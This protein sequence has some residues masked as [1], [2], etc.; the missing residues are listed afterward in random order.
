MDKRKFLSKTGRRYTTLRL[1]D[2]DDVTIR[3]L[4]GG[5][6]RLFRESL[7]DKKG[8]L[9]KRRGDMLNE[10]LL[11]RCL[12]G[13]DRQPILTDA[14]AMSGALDEMDGAVILTIAEACKKWTGFKT[15]GDFS[16]IEDA[17]K[18]SDDDRESSGC[19]V[20]PPISV[21]TT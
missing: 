1:P 20:S 7:V 13:D 14:E 3:S 11:V 4:T 16:A 10:L 12:V 6:M 9:I 5:E 15:D 18:N 8:E 17:I 21:V 2:G 19:D